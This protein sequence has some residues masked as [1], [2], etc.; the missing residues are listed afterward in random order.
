MQVIE[1]QYPPVQSDNIGLRCPSPL[2]M[3]KKKKIAVWS[4]MAKWGLL[5]FS[6]DIKNTREWG[7][8]SARDVR[9]GKEYELNL[10]KCLSSINLPVTF[11]LIK[12][13]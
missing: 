6:W 9:T 3:K 7:E 4:L 12:H 2:E 1:A 8:K 5:S 13:N 10:K 11:G